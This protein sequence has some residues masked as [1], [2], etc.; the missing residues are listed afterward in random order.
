MFIKYHY[1]MGIRVNNTS[2]PD[3]SEWKYQVGDL[4][5]SGSRDATGLLHRAYVAT[6]INYEFS[7]RGLEWE[8]LQRILNVVN[9]PEFTL[10]APDPRTF[11]GSYTGQY[12]VG[13]RTGDTHYFWSGKNGT[14]VFTL[15]LK[16][17]EY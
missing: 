5:T 7:W 8:M 1:D 3:P 2:I 4:D 15:K 9:T 16:F 17:I 10:T 14:A 13:D 12:Y 6:K 11:Q